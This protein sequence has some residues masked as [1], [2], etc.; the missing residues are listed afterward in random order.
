VPHAVAVVDGDRRLVGVVPAQRLIGFLGD[1][2]DVVP[3][4]CDSPRDK[5]GKKVISRA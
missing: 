4:V 1:D 3:G 2:E 5:G